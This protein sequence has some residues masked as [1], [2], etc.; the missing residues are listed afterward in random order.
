M[1]KTIVLL[2]I[3]LFFGCRTKTVL[4]ENIRN[5]RD[6]VENV[7]LKTNITTLEKQLLTITEQLQQTVSRNYTLIEQLD[8]SE[9]EKQSLKE[10]I[11]TTIREYN[12]QGKLIKETYTKKTSELLKDK[13]RQE[14]ENKKLTDSLQYKNTYISFLTSEVNRK[15][16]ENV[17]LTRKL[18]FAETEIIKQKQT[19]T[20]KQNGLKYLVFGFMIGLVAGIAGILYMNRLPFVSVLLEKIKKIFTKK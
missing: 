18:N 11:E 8:I 16:N 1:K 19:T 13:D 12:E 14:K 20:P 9:R 2:T 6:S 15:I 4:T 3:I 5:T 17:E 7:T 10:N